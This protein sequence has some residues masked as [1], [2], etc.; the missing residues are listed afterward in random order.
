M[1]L[2]DTS[3][4]VR[5]FTG[6]PP[7]SAQVSRRIIDDEDDLAITDVAL[8]E[9]AYVLRTAYR[10]PRE[11]IVDALIALLERANIDTFR[12]DKALVIQALLLCRPSGRVSFPDALIW[13]A[14]R[15]SG[16]ATVYTF[17]QRFPAD[18][19]EVRDTPPAA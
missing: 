9:V 10:L 4:V 18:G 16:G 2:L 6:A 17:D 7:E 3:V 12:L 19:I 13:A 1:R 8:A 15:A 5:Y 14:A 11:D